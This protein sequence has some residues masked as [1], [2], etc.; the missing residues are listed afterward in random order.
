MISRAA[1]GRPCGRAAD[2]CGGSAPRADSD[3]EGNRYPDQA[4]DRLSAAHADAGTNFNAKH[5]RDG[6]CGRDGHGRRQQ[7]G[8]GNTDRC[9]DADGSEHTGRHF[10]PHSHGHRHD[11]S[12]QPHSDALRSYAHAR[13]DR[14]A[15][16]V[17]DLLGPLSGGYRLR[18]GA[19]SVGSQGVGATPEAQ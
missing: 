4:D 6:T 7:S 13:A 17:S 2:W 5:N 9:A 10:T 15:A 3:R 1:A 19:D 12:S 18:I 14:H 8:R 16:P 11:G